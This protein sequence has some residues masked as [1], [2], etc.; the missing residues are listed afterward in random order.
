MCVI[1]FK[2][3]MIMVEMFR[4][5]SVSDAGVRVVVR[6]FPLGMLVVE[7]FEDVGMS[8]SF[9]FMS[10]GYSLLIRWTIPTGVDSVYVARSMGMWNVLLFVI[11][12]MAVTMTMTVTMTVT[13]AMGLLIMKHILFVLDL[14]ALATI[15][16]VVS[17]T[18]VTAMVMTA[19]VMTAMTVTSMTRNFVIVTTMTAM[20]A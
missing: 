14:M 9:F 19:V 16:P 11:M 1:L 6:S 13:V 3:R 7:I 4:G 12:T 10:V 5:M 20:T 17:M 18:T 8:N 2:F 15:A